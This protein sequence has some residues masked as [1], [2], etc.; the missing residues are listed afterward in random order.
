MVGE[1]KGYREAASANAGRWPGCGI[2][3]KEYAGGR[4]G[5]RERESAGAIPETGAR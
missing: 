5:I 3:G 2:R 1:E 4:S